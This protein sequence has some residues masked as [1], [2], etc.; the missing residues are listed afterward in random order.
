MPVELL[1][2]LAPL[3][4][5]AASPFAGPEEVKVTSLTLC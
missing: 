1:T 2:I 3:T 5:A 4:Q